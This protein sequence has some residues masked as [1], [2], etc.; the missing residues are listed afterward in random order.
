MVFEHDFNQYP[1]LSNSQMEV[2]EFVSPHPQITNDFYGTCTKVVDGDT[3]H[4]ATS[5]RSFDFPIRLL[6]IDSPEISEVGGQETKLWLEA[7][8]LQKEIHVLVD[9][10]NRVDKY[11][12]LLGRIFENGMDIGQEELYLGLAVPF[13]SKKEGDVPTVERILSEG[14]F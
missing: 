5:F 13:G 6:D 9:Y 1:E 7:K 14:E 10:N 11:G 4:V 2:L 8:I 3:I 12:R